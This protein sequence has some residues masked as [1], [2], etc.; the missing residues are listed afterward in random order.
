[1]FETAVGEFGTEKG[2]AAEGNEGGGTGS[3]WVESADE[4]PKV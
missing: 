1:V 3:A 4:I 2:W